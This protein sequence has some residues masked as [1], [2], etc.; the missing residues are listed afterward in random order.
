ML[1]A[2]P[3]ASQNLRPTVNVVV[4]V[5]WNLGYSTVGVRDRVTVEV[6]SFNAGDGCRLN[7]AAATSSGRQRR[8]LLLRKSQLLLNL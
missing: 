6:V 8:Y 1:I 5:G 7:A 2:I 4:I 3:T